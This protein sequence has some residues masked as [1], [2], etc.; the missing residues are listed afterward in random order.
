MTVD[1]EDVKKAYHACTWGNT[2]E[3]PED[4]F[5]IL[6]GED[7]RAKRR[8]FDRLFSEDFYGHLTR[9]LFSRTMIAD[10]VSGMTRPMWRRDLEK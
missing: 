9:K 10:F 8:L 7:M 1:I 2:L 3:T 4:W 5:A 6:S